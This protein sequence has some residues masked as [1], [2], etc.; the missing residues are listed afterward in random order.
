MGVRGRKSLAELSILTPV[1][2][3]RVRPPAGL[4]PAA[5]AVFQELTAA[6]HDGHFVETDAQLLASLAEAVTL[7][8]MAAT[9]LEKDPKWLPVWER[10]VRAQGM[11]ATKLRLTPQSRGSGRADPGRA[12]SFADKVRLGLPP[13]GDE[14]S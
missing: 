7:V 5:A 4:K 11:L 1:N 9:K 12:W 8:R 10:A 2:P 6:C 14:N 3:Y 13:W